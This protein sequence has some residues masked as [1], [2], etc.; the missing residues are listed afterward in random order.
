MKLLRMLCP[1]CNQRLAP[2]HMDR[3]LACPNC[4]AH[5]TLDN[6]SGLALIDVSYATPSSG[7]PNIKSWEPIWVFHGRV[8]MSGRI[9]RK[10]NRKSA[11]GAKQ[12]WEQ[13]RNLFVPA[14]NISEDQLREEGMRLIESQPDLIPL[15]TE[16]PPDDHLFAAAILSAT[17]AQ[18]LIDFLIL[19]LEAKRSDILKTIKFSVDVDPPTLWAVPFDGRRFLIE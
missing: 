15:E 12:L 6:Q 13:P 9:A 2:N 17:D 14:G 19:G 18:E 5:M 8:D 10:A 4:H 16:R 3:V 11:H 1:R 7:R